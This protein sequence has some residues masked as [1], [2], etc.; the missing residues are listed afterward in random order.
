[1]LH[2]VLSRVADRIYAFPSAE[3]VEVIPRVVAK[4]LPQAPDWVLGWINYRG[5]LI[6]ALD[7]S[8]L[9]GDPGGEPR[10]ANRILVLRTGEPG[11]EPNEL[12]G[13]L[14]DAVLGSER[15]DFSAADKHARLAPPQAGYLTAATLLDSQLVQLVDPR[16]LPRPFAAPEEVAC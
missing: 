14:V 12:T 11:D 13:V 15:C 8:R 10:M 1:M 6:L 2:A 16:Q 7:F 5:R 3:V 4:A 9:R